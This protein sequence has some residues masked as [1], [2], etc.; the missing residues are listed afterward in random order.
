MEETTTESLQKEAPQTDTCTLASIFWPRQ[1]KAVSA[2][3]SVLLIQ[4]YF[5]L[6]GITERRIIGFTYYR[7]NKSAGVSPH[8]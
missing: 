8:Y 4:T 3:S 2:C 1:I 5:R 6:Q 7:S